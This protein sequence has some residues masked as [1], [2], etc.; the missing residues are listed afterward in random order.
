MHKTNRENGVRDVLY[1]PPIIFDRNAFSI[2]F[3]VRVADLMWSG[4]CLSM[5]GNKSVVS[6]PTSVY[7]LPMTL[8]MRVGGW[9]T[10]PDAIGEDMHMMLKCYF[11]TSGNL[12]MQVIPSPA[13][14]CN[15]SS[16]LGGLR[17]WIACLKA[18][19]FQGLR[20]MWGALDTGF[21]INLFSEMRR[22][23]EEEEP[24][25]YSTDYSENTRSTSLK[26]SASSETLVSDNEQ[27]PAPTTKLIHT[28]EPQRVSRSYRTMTVFYRLFEAHM[29]P[30]HMA[31]VLIAST[32]YGNLVPTEKQPSE[33]IVGLLLMSIMRTIAFLLMVTHFVYFYNRYHRLAVERREAEIKRAGL[34]DDCD[35]ET[36][37]CHRSF[38]NWRCWIDCVA[39]VVGGFMFGSIPALHA[40]TGHFF[41]TRLDYVVSGKPKQKVA[42]E[43]E[44]VV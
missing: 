8:A 34:Y 44:K 20:H 13:S 25:Y 40:V 9:D 2:P 41:T 4:A 24:S 38:R 32:V 27:S 43:P 29:L 21:S 14:Q 28:P 23:G 16:S 19:Y 18:R 12:E 5:C 30:L 39:F 35:I 31:V 37:F 15:V 10:G 33:M 22:R 42:P 7:T 17:G 11:G 1:M 3:L 36:T 6:I 26:S